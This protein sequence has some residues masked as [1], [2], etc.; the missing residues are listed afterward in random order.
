MAKRILLIEDDPGIQLSIRDEFES[1]GD[2]VFSADDGESGLQL[3]KTE[4]PD[5]IILDIML[6][7][8]ILA[9]TPKRNPFRVVCL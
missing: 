2:I 9:L 6:P 8:F 5:L 3:A 7:I 1:E 4:N